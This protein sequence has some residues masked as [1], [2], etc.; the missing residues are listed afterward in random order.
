MYKIIL[1]EIVSILNDS[2][3]NKP[4]L[5]IHLPQR[6]KFERYLQS[7]LALRLKKRFDDT[8]IEYSLD[9]KHVDIYA[10]NAFI[11]LKTP[12][13]NYRLPGVVETTRPITNN[14]Q[15]IIDDINKLKWLNVNNGI[16]AFVL[17]PIDPNKNNHLQ[18]IEKIVAA[19]GHNIYCSA[20]VGN[21]FVFSCRV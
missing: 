11:E 6:A 20:N 9:D 10:N 4:I 1:D 21:M 12:N 16:V 8:M 15:S 18:H 13:T 7:V 14:I 5:D 2:V 17:F 3:W 19:L